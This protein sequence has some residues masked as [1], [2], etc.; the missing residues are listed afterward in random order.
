MSS[1]DELKD[2]VKSKSGELMGKSKDV[3]DDLRDKASELAAQH[4]DKITDAVGKAT[5]F[6]DD[7]TKG[8]LASVTD[9]VD[10]LAEKAVDAVRK[11]SGGPIS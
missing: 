8:K 10:S 3:A 5:D 2:T 9:T 1:F 7:K 11:D 4:G 6:I